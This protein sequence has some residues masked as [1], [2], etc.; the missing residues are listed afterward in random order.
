MLRFIDAHMCE[1]SL[2]SLFLA[3]IYPGLPFRA[4][5]CY[6]LPPS[7]SA[8]FCQH[9]IFNTAVACFYTQLL[10]IYGHEMWSKQRV[11]CRQRGGTR[12]RDRD[13]GRAGGSS[14][15]QKPYDRNARGDPR[16]SRN[17]RNN[18]PRD[19]RRLPG[20][21]RDRETHGGSSKQPRSDRRDEKDRYPVNDQG[22]VVSPDN[23][24]RAREHREVKNVDGKWVK[25]EDT[26]ETLSH[27]FLGISKPR[28]KN[29]KDYT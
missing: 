9:K 6:E 15:W 14:S 29:R 13:R 11:Q 4:L 10:V 20:E 2:A 25:P 8:D 22:I 28:K 16:D 1:T 17:S 26:G 5:V 7:A 23:I 19:G 3:N 24:R 12:D 27:L 21:A 18:R